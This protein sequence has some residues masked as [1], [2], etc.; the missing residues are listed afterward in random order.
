MLIIDNI[1]YMGFS[2]TERAR[3]AMPLMKTL[4]ALKTK[5]NLSM[6]VLAHT[7]KRNPGKPL[8]VNDLQGSKMLINFADSAFAIGKSHTEPGLHYLKQIKQR[9]SMGE[10]GDANICLCRILKDDNFLKFDFIGNGHEHDHLLRAANFRKTRQQRVLELY[11]SGLSCRQIATQLSI[12]FSTV[13]RM[14]H[15]LQTNQNEEG[16]IRGGE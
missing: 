16:I 15:R 9:S 5:H 8:T 6:L 2:G 10:Y 3:D 14:I 12:H 7:P 11:Q 13:S 1:T 4:K